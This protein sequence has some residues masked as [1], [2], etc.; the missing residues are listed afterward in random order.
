[1][2]KRS[3]ELSPRSPSF[4]DTYGWILYQEG[5]YDE[6]KIWLEN[7]IDYGADKNGV[8]LEHY[9][10]ILYQLDDFEEAKKQWMKA[11]QTKQGSEFLDQKIN[12]G[13]LND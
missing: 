7:A 12:T 1:M 2:S 6:A 3:N 9:G 13:K 5:K 8:I 4:A 11:K 10:D